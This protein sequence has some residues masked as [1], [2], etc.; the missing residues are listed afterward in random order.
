MKLYNKINERISDTEL[1]DVQESFLNALVQVFSLKYIKRLDEKI[2]K[3]DIRFVEKDFKDPSKAA[4]TVGR[5]I[6]VNEPV[7]DKLTTKERTKYLLH[8]FVHVMQNTKN[9]FVF[10]TF[11]EVYEVG[12]SLNKIVKKHL[13]GSLGEFLTGSKQKVSSPKYEVI[14]YLMNG[15]IDWTQITPEGRSE[16][17][18]TLGNSGIFNL[19]TK[20]WEERLL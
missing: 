3:K 6:Y 14:S 10:K 16:F 13:I 15:D 7:F 2:V 20:F 1:Y 19:S 12:A 8:E 18:K 5:T 4:Y 9:F 17:V 11:K